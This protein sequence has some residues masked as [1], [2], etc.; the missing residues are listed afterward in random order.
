ME[1]ALRL[2]QFSVDQA[3]EAILWLDPTARIFNVNDTACRMLG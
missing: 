3:V 1:K 2:T